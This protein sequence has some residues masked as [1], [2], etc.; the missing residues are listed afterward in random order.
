MQGFPA[1]FVFRLY[2]IYCIIKQA[3]KLFTLSVRWDI[4]RVNKIFNYKE[5]EE[6]IGIC[7]CT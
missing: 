5:Q 7:K 3:E 4:I 2:L 1:F 6:H